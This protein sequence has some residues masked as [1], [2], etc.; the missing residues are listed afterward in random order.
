MDLSLIIVNFNTKDIL[1]DC[2]KNLSKAL[3]SIDSEIIVV[4]NDSSDG[5]ADMVEKSFPKVILIKSKNDGLA[6]G[7]NLGLKA[8]KG[9]YLLYMGSDAFPTKETI[10]GMLQYMNENRNV[11][12][13][14]S[15][16]LLR[17]GQIDLDAHRGFPTPWASITYF[18]KLNKLFPKSKIFNQYFLGYK[19]LDNP[20]EIDLC[21]SHFMLV[22]REVFAKIGNWDE[23][24][25]LYGEDVDFCYRT[26][27]A[28]YKIMYLSQFSTLH[29]KGASVG[30]RKQTQDIS[31][32]TKEIKVKMN[33]ETTRAMRLFY[34]KHYSKKY[35]KIFT[36][37]ILFAISILEKVRS[38]RVK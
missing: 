34:Q 19:D 29:Y 25:F 20:H 31:L 33:K 7:S 10:E 9:K 14:T 2:L 35:P 15:K 26:K 27:E 18:T 17:S 23:G 28:G 24:F 5:S 11:G 4:D 38:R 22:R 37:F 36:W 12:I 13:A 21:I 1:K 6:A 8:S 16:L 3:S 32:A 30:I